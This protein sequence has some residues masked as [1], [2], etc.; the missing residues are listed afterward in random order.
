M[1]LSY[2]GRTRKVK[3]TLFNLCNASRQAVIKNHKAIETVICEAL[4]CEI[5]CYSYHESEECDYEFCESCDTLHHPNTHNCKHCEK[6]NCVVWSWDDEIFKCSEC[7]KAQY[8]GSSNSS[9]KSQCRE[10]DGYHSESEI[11]YCIHCGR[12]HE[13]YNYRRPGQYRYDSDV[14][15][16]ISYFGS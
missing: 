1:I 14:D 3:K 5:C 10:C 12:C 2:T 9:D 7:G 4:L 16:C 11:F 15:K 13:H 6:I 8:P